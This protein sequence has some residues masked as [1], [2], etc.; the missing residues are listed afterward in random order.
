MYSEDGVTE[1]YGGGTRR[2]LIIG[3]ISMGLRLGF[4][5]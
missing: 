3:N 5:L 4:S 2:L 1:K